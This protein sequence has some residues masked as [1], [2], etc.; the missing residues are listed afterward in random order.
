MKK[1]LLIVVAVLS[2]IIV[3]AQ[4]LRDGHFFKTFTDAQ[5]TALAAPEVFSQWFTLPEGTEWRE[6]RRETD[7]LG[8]EH[9]DYRQ[10]VGG[11]EVEDMGQEP[12]EGCGSMVETERTEEWGD[13]LAITVGGA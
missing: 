2:A 10:Y 9:V 7:N 8:M 5:Q 12:H 4:Q 3:E 11:V 6:T 1:I 13:L